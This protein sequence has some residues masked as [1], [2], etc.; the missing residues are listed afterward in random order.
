MESW[1]SNYRIP[2][3][4]TMKDLMD[5]LQQQAFLFDSIKATIDFLVEGL[6]RLLLM[7]PPVATV[8]AVA[9]LAYWL[10]RSLK[11]AAFVVLAFFLIIDMGYWQ[12]TVQT[13]SLIFWSATIS[14][15]IGVPI[16]IMAAH[17]PRF[18]VLLRPVLDMM[19][20]L[21]T[22]VYLIPT[23]VLFGLGAAPGLIST[24]IFAVPAP[25]RLTYL[26]ISS[27][28][29]ALK[30]TGEA[31]GA[32]RFQ[33]LR[34]IEI[35]HAIPTIMAGVT[36]CIMLCLSMVVVAA[37]VGATGLGTPVVRALGSMNVPMG[38]ESGISIVLLAIVLDRICHPPARAGSPRKAG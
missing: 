15:V 30:E 4:K 34:K 19:Q 28:P 10:H 2:V 18:Y 37:L 36:Q 31:F 14:V 22:F 33:L 25:I 21:P 24:V 12:A 1:F 5:A 16:G 9:L 32:T 23:V 38:F 27:V 35:P 7:V 6:T 3:G 20:T 8:G 13:I 17:R 26:G 29:Q 11:L